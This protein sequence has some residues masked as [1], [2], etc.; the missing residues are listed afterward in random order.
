MAWLDRDPLSV[1]ALVE[2]IR[3]RAGVCLDAL[4]TAVDPLERGD[5]SRH[6]AASADHEVE[7]ANTLFQI[8]GKSSDL[9][10]ESRA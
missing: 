7:A 1:L 3:L 10:L 6:V 2:G 9:A 4:H 5:A 8:V